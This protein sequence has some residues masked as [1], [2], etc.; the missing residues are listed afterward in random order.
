M[1]STIQSSFHMDQLPRKVNSI[2][3]VLVSKK[4]NNHT[5]HDYRLISS[6][7]MIYKCIAK[8]LANRLSK[9]FT[10]LVSWNQSMFL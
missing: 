9:V 7:N 8:I 2:S 4:E 3:I 6:C 10:H 1:N 5:I